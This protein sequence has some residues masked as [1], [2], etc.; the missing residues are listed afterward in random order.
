[1]FEGSD[2]IRGT[3]FQRSGDTTESFI[4]AVASSQPDSLT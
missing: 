3:P 2:L 4:H 1:M